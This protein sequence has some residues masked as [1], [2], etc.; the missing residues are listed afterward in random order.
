MTNG[1]NRK[2]HRVAI[3]G[4]GF[5]GLNVAKELR[6]DEAIEVTLIDRQNHHV[7]QPLLYQVATAS[8][9][10]GSVA[11]PVRSILS[12]QK[13]A[14]VIFGSVEAVDPEGQLLRLADGREVAYDSLVLACGAESFYFGNDHWAAHAT[15]LKSLDDALEI[16]ERILL[17]FEAAERE[18][19]PLERAKLLTF[20]VI[21]A[22][23]TGVEMAGAISELGRQV[24]AD[25]F[26]NIAPKDVRV[27]LVEMAPRVLTPFDE[28]LSY[29]AQSQLEELGVELKLGWRVSDVREREVTI[30]KDEVEEH[31]HS[32]V[33]I[34]ASGVRANPLIESA[35]LA[36]D[37]RGRALVD[38]QCRAQGH[39]NIYVI[40]DAAAFED[41][42]HGMLPGLAPVAI[43]QGKHLAKV[44]REARRGG[45]GPEFSYF[46]KGIMATVGRSRAIVQGGVKLTGFLAWLA[47]G[48]VH[49]LFLI[50]FRNRA[51][52][53]FNW[54]WSYLTYQRGARLI[55]GRVAPSDPNASPEER[56]AVR[57]NVHEKS[58]SI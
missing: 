56:A 57:D 30:Q 51:I 1:E 45:I 34:W 7:F 4:A 58:T 31:L 28:D 37:R 6:G 33:T 26:A 21:G 27:V 19:D 55:T 29:A 12:K 24:L 54:F 17:T 15:G 42:K 52:V 18:S 25:D 40:G 32:S 46:D 48:L 14:N 22:G 38:M 3:V 53:T 47:W 49:I 10:P 16:R 23:P 41:R 11:M 8:L 13:N 43:Q 2:R 36:T 39:E 5:G 20:V 44:L 35:G 9:A 50:G